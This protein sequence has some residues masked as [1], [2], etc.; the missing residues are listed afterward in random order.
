MVADFHGGGASLDY[1]PHASTHFGLNTSSEH[2]HLS[3]DLVSK[4][5]VPHVMVFENSTD[6]GGL[7]DA[8][9]RQGVISLGGEY[10]GA[11]S[12]S[13]SGVKLVQQAVDR[14]LAASGG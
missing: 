13:R 8:A 6:K 5:G 14:L 11:G 3:L 9:I 4:L 10:G 7:P 1:R 2:K 12:V